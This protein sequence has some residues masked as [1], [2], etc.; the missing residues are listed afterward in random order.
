MPKARGVW[1]LCGDGWTNAD[2][3]VKNAHP[4]TK[5][6]LGIIFTLP[7]AS[8]RTPMQPRFRL[9]GKRLGSA[10]IDASIK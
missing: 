8:F 10:S 6:I 1:T 3:E 7:V 9:A 5:A 4:A 2:I